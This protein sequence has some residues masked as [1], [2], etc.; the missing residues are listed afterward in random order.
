MSSPYRIAVIP[1]DGIG[2]EVVEA[3]LLVLGATS[4]PFEFTTYSAG[5]GCR[6][7]TGEALPPE[8]LE[9]ALAAQAV[10]FGAVGSS[11]AEVILRLR[12]E[13]GTFVN[14]RPVRAAEG[15]ECI[16]PQT[17]LIILRENSEGM[18]AGIENVI[19]PGVVTATRVLTET[20]SRRIARYAF[21]YARDNGRGKVTAVHKANVLKKSD[22]LF[23]EC[24][25]EV[26]SEFP[27]IP[28]EEGLVDSVAMRIVLQPQDFDVIV[29]TNLFGDILSDLAAGVIGGL[30]MCPSANLGLEHALFEPVH[31][32]APDIAGKGV[33]NPAAAIQCGALLLKYLGEQ[34]AAESVETALMRSVKEGL[35]TPDLGGKLSTMEMAGEVARL[36]R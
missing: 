24:C 18:Y 36:M 33:A 21:E 35:T 8:T 5:D 3:E 22:G 31:G 32:S 1:G 27:R 7:K 20:A 2:P 23:L 9:G 11:A 28:F 17:D 4:L 30:G 15:V 13:L 29:T 25:R 34:A 26:A 6:D 16:H 19:I 12:R 14:L 10:I